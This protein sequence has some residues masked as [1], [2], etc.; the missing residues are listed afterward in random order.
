MPRK[1]FNRYLVW[2]SLVGAMLALCPALRA[3][4]AAP[5]VCQASIITDPLKADRSIV[6]GTLPGQSCVYLGIPYAAP[7]V[8]TPKEPADPG[9]WRPPAA[10]T[11]WHGVKS[12]KEFGHMCPQL[13]IVAGVTKIGRAHV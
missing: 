7:P 13:Q 5:P 2:F 3:Q 10:V 9:R 8:G 1:A 11:P 12:F 6:Q 4:D